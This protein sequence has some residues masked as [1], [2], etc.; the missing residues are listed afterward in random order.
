MKKFASCLLTVLMVCAMLTVFSLPAMAATCGDYEYSVNDD[1]TATITGYNGNGGAVTI[2]ETLDGYKVTG[3]GEEAFC[4][5]NSITELTI[6]EGVKSIGD[7]A[8]CFCDIITAVTIP[9]SVETIGNLAFCGCGNITELTITEGV[10]SIGESAFENCYQLKTVTIPGSVESIG[11]SAFENCGQLKTVTISEGVKS[12][13]DFAFCFCNTITAVTIPGSV[14]SIGE[15]A[16][17]NCYQL[18][19]VTVSEGVKS[20]GAYAFRDCRHLKTVTI[21][22]SVKRIG[23]SAFHGCSSDL[24]IY[25]KRGSFADKYTEHYDVPFVAVEKC[26][27]SGSFICEDCNESLTKDELLAA[28]GNNATG[29]ASILSEGNMTVVVGIAAA[30]VFGLAGFLFG[31]KKKTASGADKE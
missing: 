3:I 24:V 5:C 2:P 1:G 7:L 29:S 13:G 14:E 19:T 8:F 23:E 30:V 31:R 17:E 9:G 26:D 11:E 16:F 6:S 10:K 21:P 20:I 12:I 4:F 25:G 22:G 27:H 15:S 18:K 28:W